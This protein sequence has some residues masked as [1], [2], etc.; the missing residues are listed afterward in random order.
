[1]LWFLR[2]GLDETLAVQRGMVERRIERIRE[3]EKSVL[4]KGVSSNPAS[5]SA[6]AVVSAGAG[7]GAGEEA[8][9]A[10][11]DASE[12][13]A[14]EAELSPQQ[15]QLFAEENEAMVRYYEETLSKVQYVALSF[16]S[17]FRLL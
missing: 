7:A 11:L 2:R 1:V 13:A 15:L 6:A 8:R 16:L 3:R 17:F 5:A 14:I 10:A 12:L 9:G 4:Y